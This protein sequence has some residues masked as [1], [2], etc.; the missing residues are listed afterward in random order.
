MVQRQFNDFL[1]FFLQLNIESVTKF[2][3]VGTSSQTSEIQT[4]N[5]L[6]DFDDELNHTD[7]NISEQSEAGSMLSLNSSALGTYDVLNKT[8]DSIPEIEIL[9]E[10]EIASIRLEPNHQ[11]HEKSI[12]YAVGD[13]TVDTASNTTV[14]A[15][16]ITNEIPIGSIS[17]QPLI[18]YTIRL[19]SSKFLLCGTSYKLIDGF[20]VRISIKNLS[21]AVIGH[22]VALC[23]RS[24]L[25]SLQYNGPENLPID[26]VSDSEDSECLALEKSSP[27][28]DSQQAAVAGAVAEPSDELNI[29]DDHF[30]ENSKIPK[31][32]F[33]FSFPL[34]KSA[35]NVLLSRLTVSNNMMMGS[36][37]L[38]YGDNM[39]KRTQKLSGDLNNLLSKSEI[40]ESNRSY[41]DSNLDVTTE[42]EIESNEKM[43]C[44]Q[45]LI[46]SMTDGSPQFVEDLLLF[47]NHSD[48]MLRANIQTLI[49]N[50]LFNVLNECNSIANY[51]ET[52][53]IAST[54]RF[55]NSNVLFHILMKVNFPKHL[56]I[57]WTRRYNNR[58]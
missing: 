6:D 11:E 47:W 2:F 48:P 39:M 42:L 9:N 57:T 18:Y 53:E 17:N 4:P 30:G 20:G 35:D 34:S 46:Q 40:I 43:L 5:V 44:N 50:F 56:P 55:L 12:G 45:T 14:E 33:D 51:I 54:Y 49:G 1:S 15:T 19:I 31:T 13:Q 28:K 27:S 10:Q 37:G 26:P 23:P 24:L 21:L 8:D 22:C 25:L 29:K 7:T 41:R 3:R 52:L 16:V 36:D 38:T 32:Y 58:E